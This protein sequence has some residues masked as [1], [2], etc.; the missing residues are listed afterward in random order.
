MAGWRPLLVLAVLLA[1]SMGPLATPAVEA[2]TSGRT[3]D[4][5]DLS[6]TAFSANAQRIGDGTCQQINIG[7]LTPGSHLE[8]ALTVSN[9]PVDLLMFDSNGLQVYL[10]E[11]SYR[12]ENVWQRDASLESRIGNVR[13]IWQVPTE[14]QTR[15]WFLIIDN[16]NHTGDD[17]QGGQGGDFADVTGSIAAYTPGVFEPYSDSSFHGAGSTALLATFNL[18]AGT[19][20][21]VAL[22]GFQGDADV[23]LLSDDQLAISTQETGI[24]LEAALGLSGQ[25]TMQ[26]IV[27]T[28]LAG[29]AV[30]LL[31][32]NADGAPA[33]GAHTGPAHVSITVSLLPA[34]DPTVT[35]EDGTSEV[36][37]GQSVRLSLNSTP[38][39]SDQIL[40]ATWDL[41]ASIDADQ[42]GNLTNDLDAT[43]MWAA[44]SWTSP[45]LRT[46]T[47]TVTLRNSLSKTDSFA[48][49]VADRSP[50]EA[51]LQVR[52]TTYQTAAQVTA[53]TN[54]ALTFTSLSTDNH[55][56]E[57]YR[58]VVDGAVRSDL[59]VG[60]AAF[61]WAQ[62]G[63]HEIQ[64]QV[65]D[66]AGHTDTLNLS[67]QVRDDS[68]P[69]IQD[70][71][72]PPSAEAG[73]QVELSV[74]FNDPQWPD[75]T[76]Y[77]VTWDF[78]SSVDS[79]ADGDYRNDAQASG[80]LA[81]WT[82]EEERTYTIV[83][84]VRNPDGEFSR[85]EPLN[86]LVGAP[87]ADAGALGSGLAVALGV[88]ALAI[89]FIG[90]WFYTQNRR[91]LEALA[92]QQLAAQ[93]AAAT[94][95]AEP[96]ST[97][98]HE[99]YRPGTTGVTDDR[100]AAEFEFAAMANIGSTPAVTSANK[101]A[102]DEAEMARLAGL[103]PTPVAQAGGHAYDLDDVSFLTSGAGA[104]L[105]AAGASPYAAPQD[106]APQDPYGYAALSGPAEAAPAAPAPAPAAGAP[107]A[108][109]P[110]PAHD[111]YA[112]AAAVDVLQAA[113]AVCDQAF[114]VEM[115]KGVPEAIVV[116]PHCGQRQIYQ[117]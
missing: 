76:Q 80:S 115:P 4:C 108:A 38:N 66:P 69:I 40:T 46:V 48:V 26:W 68:G 30:H 18:D 29:Q 117:R 83:V 104:G 8:I 14:L 78:D 1:A 36:D 25:A 116:C 31:L 22:T 35:S 72:L 105:G 33:G 91:A 73:E 15:S 65:A 64:L 107:A 113:C 92:A 47:A 106:I 102:A 70:V 111:P 110:A 55:R 44:A 17:N 67:V 54:T 28:E 45:G 42:D 103:P 6:A 79:N 95:A 90:L 41:D 37:V 20:I 57:T 74:S 82:F 7:S 32:D 53:F 98:Q 12:Q 97:E 23:F 9:T 58:W 100:T 63:L 39:R 21:A 51:R 19:N 87:A 81:R 88:T 16:L 59:T 5:P 85:S 94:P 34:L 60:T 49:L 61:Q 109:A 99:M 112:A 11:Q 62:V 101:R 89:V 13:A 75:G 2:E 27:P 50:P 71:R 114:A 93:Q 77:E 10:N 86:L 43:G 24:W 84:T 56:V 96:T 52:T 3:I